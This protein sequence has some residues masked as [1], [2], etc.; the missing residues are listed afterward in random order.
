M[1]PGRQSG[2]LGGFTVSSLKIKL[3][4]I[5]MARKRREDQKFKVRV[6]QKRYLKH[7]QVSG[8]QMTETTP[9]PPHLTCHL[10]L[11]T[12]RDSLGGYSEGGDRQ[13]TR[14]WEPQWPSR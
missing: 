8:T 6:V 4:I 11:H 5:I 1:E 7:N 9:P 14:K 12:I 2:K 10:R 13:A 3:I